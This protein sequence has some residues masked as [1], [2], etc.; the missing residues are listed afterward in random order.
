L[1]RV[2][3]AFIPSSRL[4]IATTRTHA[5]RRVSS[6]SSSSLRMAT[7]SGKCKVHDD[8][9]CGRGCGGSYATRGYF[10][11][12]CSSHYAAPFAPKPVVA[13]PPPVHPDHVID[14][15]SKAVQDYQNF[16]ASG[17]QEIELKE[18]GASVLVRPASYEKCEQGKLLQAFLHLGMGDDL[19]VTPDRTIPATL[20]GR[21]EFPIYVLLPPTQLTEFLSTLN[22]SLYDKID[23]FI[24]VS[25]S[26]TYGNIEDV[27]K[28]KGTF[29]R[30]TQLFPSQSFERLH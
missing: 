5:S 23:D 19:V 6:T 14:P 26:M 17:R 11:L 16:L 30:P 15:D 25:G 2:A 13:S 3:C 20:G 21:N 8:A 12:L 27:L 29:S 28:E 4:S 9:V 1:S 22:P 24:F 10:L 7:W 18:D